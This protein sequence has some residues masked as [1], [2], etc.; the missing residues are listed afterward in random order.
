MTLLPDDR[1]ANLF[2]D[3][4]P[5]AALCATAV[6]HTVGTCSGDTGGPLVVDGVLVGIVSW[7]SEVCTVGEP[8]AYTR[9]SVYRKFIESHLYD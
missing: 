7:I 5:N 3:G 2:A 8:T 4:E 1:C 9:V 6:P